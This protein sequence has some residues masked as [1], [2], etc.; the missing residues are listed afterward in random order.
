VKLSPHFDLAEFSSPEYAH[1]TGKQRA[2]GKTTPPQKYH[3]NLRRL[4]GALEVLRAVDDVPIEIVSGWR[5]ESYNKR[6][7]GRGSRSQHLVGKAADIRSAASSPAVLYW[8][9]HRLMSQG[10][11]PRGGLACYPTFVHYDTRGW[12]ARWRRAPPRPKGY[13]PGP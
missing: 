10:A 11:I 9:L 3:P 8:R 2:P 1:A 5:S 12:P 7:K 6:N 13:T 4:C